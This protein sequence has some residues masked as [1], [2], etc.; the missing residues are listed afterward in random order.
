MDDPLYPPER[1]IV[2]LHCDLHPHR[3]GSNNPLGIDRKNPQDSIPF[4]PYYTVKDLFGLC[5]FLIVFA[6]FVFYLSNYLNGADAYI[7]ANPLQT[8]AEIVPQWYFLPFYAIL[9]SIPDKLRGVVAMFSAVGVLFV[10]PWL[11][12]SKVRSAYFR[13]I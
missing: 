13:P 12:T 9:R 6:I 3:H 7:P 5:V 2:L 1:R 11:D 4:H 8:P 10:V